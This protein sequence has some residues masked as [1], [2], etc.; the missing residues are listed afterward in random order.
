MIRKLKKVVASVTAA[1]M[2]MSIVPAINVDAAT[3]ST[4]STSELPNRLLIGYW[5]NFDNAI[6]TVMKLRDV[7]DNWDVINVSFGETDTSKDR[8]TILFTP[9]STIESES[10][11]KEDV[12]YLQSKGKKVVLSIGGQNGEVELTNA[13]AK[14]N[15]VKSVSGLVDKYG[16]DGLDLDLEQFMKTKDD[17]KNPTNAQNINLIAGCKE[18]KAKYGDN[19]MLTMA[20]ETG[21]VQDCLMSGSG[22][23]LPLIYGLRDILTYVSVQYYNS[24]PMNGSDGSPYQQGTVDFVVALVEMLLN[25]FEVGW[26]TGNMFPALR[27]DQVVIGLPA[28]KAAAPNGGYLSEED[29]NKAVYALTKGES[30]GGRYTMQNS[31]GYPNLRG[32]MAWSTNWDL[33]EGCK[34]STNAR[35][36]LDSLPI[37]ENTLQKASVSSTTPANGSYTLTV[38]VPGRNTATSYELYENNT[39][40]SSG[41]LNAGTSAAQ[42]KTVDVTNKADGAYE[43]KV[44]LKDASGNTVTSD[45]LKLTLSNG[46]GNTEVDEEK[47]LGVKE[48]API[49]NKKLAVGFWQNFGDNGP[50]VK[51]QKLSETD[52]RWDVLNVSFG[53]AY[54]TDKCVVE[55]TPIYDEKE[56]IQDI[57]DI[58]KEGR[59][60]CLSIGG[61][62]GAIN[63]NKAES[64]DKFVNSVCA[65]IDKYGFDGLDID[66]ETGFSLQGQDDLD[67]P[68][69]PCIVN[70]IKAFEK[71]I[72]RYGDNFIFSM[73]PQNTDIQ[74]GVGIQYGNNWGSYLPIINKLRDK[75]TYVTPQYYNN[76]S[77]CGHPIGTP[78]CLVG[79][80][81]M[82]LQGFEIGYGTNTQFFK[83]LR[84][85]QV[86]IGVPACPGASNSEGQIAQSKVTQALA[87][88]IEGKSFGGEHVLAQESYPD[89]RGAMTWSTNWDAS[90]GNPFLAGPGEYLHSV[91]NAKPSLKAASIKA[92][93]PKN[94]SYTVTAT[95]P[96][97]N[98]ATSYK[99][100]EGSTVIESGSLKE[101]DRTITIEKAF[102][103]KTEG[104]YN[105]KIVLTDSTGKS[106]TSETSV[107]VTASSNPGTT[108]DCDVNGDGKV[109]ALDIALLAEK[110]NASTGDS[111]YDSKYDL[112]NDG[113]I[114][115]YDLVKI[116]ASFGSQST[117]EPST[118]NEW[119]SGVSYKV[120]DV[121]EYKGKSYKCIMA[122][123]SH[124]GWLPGETAVIW[125]EV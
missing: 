48:A 29:L 111:N 51:F 47:P 109:D 112:N 77:Q 73:A 67:N 63:F 37:V 117:E 110:Y 58:H 120:G 28:T 72:D 9:D 84:A 39:K 86:L 3:K 96:S 8:S 27:E 62:N 79:E 44:V 33:K 93:T 99:L 69:T 54:D 18:L 85:D 104:T 40:I 83:P 45:I 13:A 105:Y 25:G 26:G 102:S 34:F 68:T 2:L 49:G 113:I 21:Y 101:N 30:Y 61:Q 46:S 123:V 89:F 118:G 76:G 121:V 60:V 36:T 6:S 32:I 43:Y 14:D 87:Y 75:I 64:V 66:I 24:G 7:N 115:V 20:P 1:M 53:E 59:R 114:D 91:N 122:H 71:I 41:L 94:G 106:V 90:V 16:F 23:Y 92:T 12:K 56:F 82:L 65:V 50:N 15:F 52:K 119:K 4:N 74:G 103:G 38:S 80:S 124:E 116:G 19:F 22:G 35:K 107:T 70:G 97:N 10:E 88:L 57:K 108:L 98:T 17:F 100:Y 78:D 125:Q 42:I 5:H 55:F 95:I 81:E 31:N 11:F